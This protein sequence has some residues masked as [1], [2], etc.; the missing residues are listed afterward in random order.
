MAGT[1]FSNVCLV[2][3][4]CI[5][6]FNEKGGLNADLTRTQRGFMSNLPARCLESVATFITDSMQYNHLS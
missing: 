4:V 5:C 6:V 2:S 3:S 1:F